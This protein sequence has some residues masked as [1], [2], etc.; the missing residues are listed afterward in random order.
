MKITSYALLILCLLDSSCARYSERNVVQ[1]EGKADVVQV[2]NS[3]REMSA[4]ISQAQQ[5]SDD[6]IKALK[7]PKSNQSGFSVKY[8]FADG[9]TVE[10]MWVVDLNYDGQA[11]AGVLNN[12]PND[13]RN[14]SF[15]Q[16]VTIPQAGISDWMYVEDGRLIGGFTMRVLF[17]DYSPEKLREL[18]ESL[19]FKV[20]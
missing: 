18:E 14:F 11:F 2:E 13:L 3:D 20:E 5:T 12:Y 1:R 10:H 4:A 9:P 8:P 16:K 19:G 7:S 6:F 17:K 15:G